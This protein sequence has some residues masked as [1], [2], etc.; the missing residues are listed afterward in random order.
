MLIR[1]SFCNLSL[2]IRFV[3]SY[4]E[5]SVL[6]DSNSFIE[7]IKSIFAGQTVICCFL[8]LTFLYGPAA[9]YLLERFRL[10]KR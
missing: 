4:L 7:I 3:E 2:E 5:L 6:Q 9:L 8:Q 10:D 1:D